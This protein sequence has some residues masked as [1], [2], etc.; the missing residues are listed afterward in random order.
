MVNSINT[1]PGKLGYGPWFN[2]KVQRKKCLHWVYISNI[3]TFQKSIQFAV[4]NSV[5]AGY[6]QDVCKPVS[7]NISFNSWRQLSSMYGWCNHIA[8]QAKSLLRS[9][10]VASLSTIP[11]S[12]SFKYN[13]RSNISINFLDTQTAINVRFWPLNS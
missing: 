8:K 4:R 6:T 2:S 13:S 7:S 1:R 5:S 12:L 11:T 3:I 9:S 10:A